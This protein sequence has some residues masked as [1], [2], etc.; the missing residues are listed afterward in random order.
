MVNKLFYGVSVVEAKEY[1]QFL[2]TIQVNWSYT[3]LLIALVQRYPIK[4]AE[5]VQLYAA[6]K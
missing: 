5:A 4:L 3:K 1:I 2:E 6:I